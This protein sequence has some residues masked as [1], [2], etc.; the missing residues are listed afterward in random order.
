MRKDYG[1]LF[2]LKES[3]RKHGLI[4]PITI[5]KKYE[6]LAGYRRLQAAKDLGWPDIECNIINAKSRL[7]KFEIET[8]ENIVRKQFTSEEMVII[9]EMRKQLSAHGFRKILYWIKRFLGLFKIFFDWIKS[10]FR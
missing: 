1:N 5:N 3:M 10:L 6:L 9:E 4:S 8:D 2:E 7:E